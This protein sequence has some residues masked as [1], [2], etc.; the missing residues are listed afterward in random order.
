MHS[1]K[2]I[3]FPNA[4]SSTINPNQETNP[5]IR[6]SNSLHLHVNQLSNPMSSLPMTVSSTNMNDSAFINSRLRSSASLAKSA[7]IKNSPIPPPRVNFNEFS[8]NHSLPI[9]FDLSD[10]LNLNAVKT[11]ETNTSSFTTFK[12]VKGKIGLIKN[13]VGAIKNSFYSRLSVTKLTQTPRIKKLNDRISLQST[14]G[15]VHIHLFLFF[16]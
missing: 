3:F 7:S 11:A 13:L 9:N 6:T 5:S 4:S 1:Q 16:K 10:A 8:D 14:L 15:K 2:E 12:D